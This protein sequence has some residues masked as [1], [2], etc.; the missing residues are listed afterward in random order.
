VNGTVEDNTTSHSNSNTRKLDDS[1]EADNSR[2]SDADAGNADSFDDDSTPPTQDHTDQQHTADLTQSLGIDLGRRILSFAAEPPPASNEHSSL[3]AA[4]A[5]GEAGIGRGAAASHQS[6]IA[7]SQRRRIAT[8][9]ERVLDAPGLVDD[10]YLNLLDWSSTNYVAIALSESVYIW[11][12]E[13]GDVGCLCSVTNG[14]ESSDEIVCSVKFSED[15]SYL[16]V[17][18]SS[19]PIQ[20]YDLSTSTRIRTMAGHATRVPS[21]SWSGAILSSGSRDG[22]IWNS[23]VRVA[24]HKIAEMNGHRAEVCGLEWRKDTGLTGSSSM[25]GSAGGMGL[26]AS[27]GNDNVVNV[28]D[29]RMLSAPKMMKTN[30]TAAVKVGCAQPS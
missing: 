28:W 18:T 8:T 17:G 13:T 14:D 26:L 4:Y 2:A 16:A 1:F 27:G 10:Y 24:Q 29:G 20:I 11:N 25:G 6:S 22:S 15:G 19:G 21:L 7:A 12:A 30:H 9:P 23:D 3:L 5:R